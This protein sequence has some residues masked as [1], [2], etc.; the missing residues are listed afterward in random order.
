MRIS[1]SHTE[2]HLTWL[3]TFVDERKFCEQIFKPQQISAL[4][5]VQ[6]SLLFSYLLYSKGTIRN[7]EQIKKI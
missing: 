3:G 1:L 4:L 2:D 5:R 6:E 7:R